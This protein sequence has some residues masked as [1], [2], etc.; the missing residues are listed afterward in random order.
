MNFKKTL[1]LS[2]VLLLSLSLFACNKDEKEANTA[3]TTNNT[4]VED[5]EEVEEN[6][7]K[8]FIDNEEFETKNPILVT[9]DNF[10]LPY[11][12]LAEKLNTEL[13]ISTEV[14]GEE[15]IP[16]IEI[17]YLDKN[18]YFDDMQCIE[19]FYPTS[20]IYYATYIR[21]ASSI[22]KKDTTK[23][24][25][26]IAYIPIDYLELYQYYFDEE[27]NKIYLITDIENSNLDNNIK[28]R[29]I[30]STYQRQYDN[31]IS[32]V[33]TLDNKTL[34]GLNKN[35]K[36]FPHSPGS[37]GAISASIYPL[38]DGD[39]DYSIL[40]NVDLTDVNQDLL[41][42][43]ISKTNEL[44]SKASELG[45]KSEEYAFKNRDKT[46]VDD[47]GNKLIEE[48][49]NTMN[50]SYDEVITAYTELIFN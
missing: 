9:K 25:D 47:E 32:S 42:N 10:L 27:N 38:V 29:A 36:E 21:D 43:Y 7:P 16:K 45:F 46:K 15:T 20:H 35:N 37:F 14:I 31:F 24:M 48:I 4:K 17:K 28:Y 8:L 50:S 23:I 13:V 40:K 41:N 1:S 6:I 2:L 39:I 3:N 33:N 44:N 26:D 22:Y 34:L 19:T 18:L 12:D 11:N 49:K 5:V 30:L